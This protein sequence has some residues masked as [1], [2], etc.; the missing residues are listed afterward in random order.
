MHFNNNLTE[1][2][3]LQVIKEDSS[4]SEQYG[5][6]DNSKAPTATATDRKSYL[7][8]DEQHFNDV[9]ASIVSDTNQES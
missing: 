9:R 1:E 2:E 4:S 5:K 6:V 7:N 3:E 8:Y